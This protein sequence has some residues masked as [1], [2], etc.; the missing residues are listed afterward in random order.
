MGKG[1]FDQEFG[2]RRYRVHHSPRKEMGAKQMAEAL[3][4][5]EQLGYLWG[6]QSSVESRMTICTVVEQLGD[7]CVPLHGR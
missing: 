2:G 7:R 6:P 3:G 5:A 1:P 4:F